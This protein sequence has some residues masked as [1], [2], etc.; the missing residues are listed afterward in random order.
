MVF[1]CPNAENAIKQEKKLV[2][3]NLFIFCSVRVK[4]YNSIY[5]DR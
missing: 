2:K 1:C 3:R 5:K 4:D